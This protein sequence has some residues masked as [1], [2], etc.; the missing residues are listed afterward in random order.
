[1]H[2]GFCKAASVTR[3]YDESAPWWGGTPAVAAVRGRAAT[4]QSA[5]QGHS[6]SLSSAGPRTASV[7]RLP[8]LSSPWGTSELGL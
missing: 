2:A 8:R 3:I 1:M 6:L 7:P 4:I 5:S